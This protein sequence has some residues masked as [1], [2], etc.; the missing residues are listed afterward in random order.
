MRV[1]T[2]ADTPASLCSSNSMSFSGNIELSIGMSTLALAIP[3][4]DLAQSENFWT[5][6][7]VGALSMMCPLSGSE[8]PPHR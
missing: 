4:W 1:E 8:K 7:I 2:P 5:S 6:A 3:C